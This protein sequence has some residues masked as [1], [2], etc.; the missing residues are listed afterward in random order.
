MMRYI[1]LNHYLNFVNYT[2]LVVKIL[3]T[4]NISLLFALSMKHLVKILILIE[5]GTGIQVKKISRY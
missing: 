1:M 3:K 4:F 5:N 2:F